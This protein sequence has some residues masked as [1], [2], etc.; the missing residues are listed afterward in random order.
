MAKP[1]VVLLSGGLDSATTAAIA[2][3]EGFRVFALS[4]DYGQ[5]HRLSSRP[6]R[7]GGRGR[8]RAA[9]HGAALILGNFGG[10]ALTAD[11]AVPKSRPPEEMNDRDSD[12]LRAGPQHGDA[13]ACAGLGRGAGGR[14]YFHRR[15]RGRLQR[16]SRLPARVHRRLSRSWR[17]WRRKP[18]SRAH[19]R[20]QFHAPLCDVDESGHR[21]PR[22]GM[23]VD[24]RLD[25]HLLGSEFDRHASA[26]ACD[27]ASCRLPRLCR[28]RA[29]DP[30]KY[31]VP[32]PRRKKRGERWTA[33]S[34]SLFS[35]AR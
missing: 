21:S 17:I 8:S 29:R 35:T 15:E 9:Y 6:L 20:F 28:S 22:H 19:S 5:R 27:A 1:A 7:R 25:A 13:L 4:V 16:L 30:L 2:R 33:R 14:R 23:G 34:V 31:Q 18:A 26:G 32:S 24:L 3:A 11:I 12:H 10:S